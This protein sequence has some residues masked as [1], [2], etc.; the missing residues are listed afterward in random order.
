MGP[1]PELTRDEELKTVEWIIK[2]AML[3]FPMHPEEV[4]D[5][6]QHFLNS[7]NRITK[8]KENRPGRKWLKLFLK[9]QPAV[10]KRNAEIISKARV[11]VKEKDVRN[12]VSQLQQ[13]LNDESASYILNDTSSIF[14]ADE[15]GVQICPKT[16][17]ILGLKNYKDTHEIA[18]GKESRTVLCN[19]S[20]N[21]VDV[22]PYIVYPY[23]RIP[24]DVVESVP[25]SWSIG[26]SHT[27]WMVSTKFFAY[28]NF[29]Y[30]Y[31]QIKNNIK[32]QCC[33][34]WMDTNPI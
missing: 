31:R 16:G 6:K 2:K 20:A 18:P 22:P 12:W 13:H 11:S 9:R 23:K 27:G 10:T 25:D 28:I 33:F 34:F 7:T 26:R 30:S 14:N 8:F 4:F 1:P 29:F 21:G 15:T 17:L 24:R 32:L 19:F 5:T 3:D